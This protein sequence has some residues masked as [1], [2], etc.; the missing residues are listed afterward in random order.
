MLLEHIFQLNLIWKESS[1]LAQRPTAPWC[2]LECGEWEQTGDSFQKCTR[3][4]NEH[5][6]PD[7]PFFYLFKA[8]FQRRGHFFHQFFSSTEILFLTERCRE[9]FLPALFKGSPFSGKS[10]KKQAPSS[11]PYP[12]LYGGQEGF[13]STA[14]SPDPAMSGKFPGQTYGKHVSWF[15]AGVIIFLI[16]AT[17]V[18]YV[19]SFPWNA[20]GFSLNTS[21]T[22]PPRSPSAPRLGNSFMQRLCFTQ[23]A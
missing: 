20:T 23:V 21:V 8:K 16:T 1:W 11:V 18:L 9:F 4:Q 15:G 6:E 17:T 7:S 12:Q 5:A 14:M 13:F 22:P 3:E 2:E 19:F 10:N